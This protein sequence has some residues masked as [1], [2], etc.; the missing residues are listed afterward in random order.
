MSIVPPRYT[1]I[2]R[3]G[4][5]ISMLCHILY[6]WKLG[7][8]LFTGNITVKCNHRALSERIHC[9]FCDDNVLKRPDNKSW[10]YNQRLT[11]LRE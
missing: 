11:L 6:L 4:V 7:T 5:D 2:C 3:A 9:P 8:P 1:S 10:F